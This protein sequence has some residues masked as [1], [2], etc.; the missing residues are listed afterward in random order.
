MKKTLLLLFL[1]LFSSVILAETFLEQKNR[2]W[3]SLVVSDGNQTRFRGYTTY[4]ENGDVIVY[5]MDRLSDNCELQYLGMNIVGE[6]AAESSSTSDI[7][8]GQ[9]RIDDY[10]THDITYKVSLTEGASTIFLNVMDFSGDTHLI[11]EF[12]RGKIVRFK[13]KT[14]KKEH[15]LRFSLN[16]Y[17]ESVARTL[18]LCKKYNQNSDKSYFDNPQPNKKNKIK[19]NVKDDASYF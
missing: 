1:M 13:L 5:V 14:E 4:A 18:S 16:G 3:T 9:L 15:F 2:D 19:K 7:Q 10:S 8:F 17:K 6:T 12:E 11:S